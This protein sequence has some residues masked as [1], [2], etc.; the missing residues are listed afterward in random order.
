MHTNLEEISN[1]PQTGTINWLNDFGIEISRKTPSGIGVILYSLWLLGILGMILLISKSIFQFHILKKS[2]LPLQNPSI[3]KLYQECL[4]EMN[5]RKTIPIYS[6]AFLKSPVIAGLFKP[7]I[8]LPIHLISDCN[9]KDIRY[10]LLHEL[11]HY[12]Y[13]DVL[14]NYLMNLF[15]VLYWFNPLVWYALKEMKSDREIACD[16]SVLKM[17][18]EDAYEEYGNTLINFAEKVSHLSFPFATGIGGNMIQMR[19]RIWNIANYHPASFQKKIYSFFTYLLITIFFLGCIPML[20]IQAIDKNHY[21]FKE[22]GKNITYIDLNAS[23]GKNKGSFILYDATKDSWQIY[24]KKYATTRISPVSTY[25]I[26]SAL[27][28]LESKII[29]PEQS[30]LPWNGQHYKYNLWNTDQTLKS[31]MQNSVT[32]YFQAIDQQT[33]LSTIRNYIQKIGY[34]N[35]IVDGDISSYWADSSLKI[36]PIEQVEMLKKFYYNQFDFS[37]ENIDTVKNSIRLFSTDTGTLYGKTGTEEVNGHNVSGWF[38]GYI[39][40]DN[41]IYFFATNI[42]NEEFATGPIATELTFS[43]LSN[44]KLWN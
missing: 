40:R 35:Q 33:D 43:I 16:T 10:M 13:K 25:K 44:L 24:N 19:K 21:S 42:Q 2:A 22:Q 38:I 27:F 20:S 37:P 18:K 39:E 41:H 17:L 31:A 4:K 15:S 12:K 32:W 5:I 23:F 6:I 36:S 28:A 34:G 26:Y 7:G 29:F 30:F 11:C 3:H 9:I 1:F 14:V 8:Y